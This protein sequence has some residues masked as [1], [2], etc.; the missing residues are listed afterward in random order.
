MTTQSNEMVGRREGVEAREEHVEHVRAERRVTPPVDVY[1]NE[2]AIMLLVDVPGVREDGLDIRLE[3]GQLELEAR[4]PK[5]ESELD[6]EPVAFARTFI[7]P[8]TVDAAKVAAELDKGVL[9][10][11]LPKSEAAKPRRIAIQTR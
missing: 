6:Y 3:G 2:D 5:P 1:E 9:K 7:V 8:N 4:Q 10:V 11:L